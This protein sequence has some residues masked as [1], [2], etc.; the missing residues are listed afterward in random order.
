MLLEHTYTNVVRR[1]F[2]PTAKRNRSLGRVCLACR[3]R[4]LSRLPTRSIQQ[5]CSPAFFV[6]EHPD[7]TLPKPLLRVEPR[8]LVG[9]RSLAVFPRPTARLQLEAHR[10][11]VDGA[12]RRKD[13]KYVPHRQQEAFGP[14]LAAGVPQTTQ[15]LSLASPF[16]SPGLLEFLVQCLP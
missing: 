14:A 9:P 5:T 3:P 10:Q 7:P 6:G 4:Y 2:M 15:A 12:Y 11:M 16:G 8:V 1:R 13:Q